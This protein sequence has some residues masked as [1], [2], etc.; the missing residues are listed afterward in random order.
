MD[1]G[2]RKNK[3]KEI[4]CF[5]RII[6]NLENELL[7]VD[8][9]N[10]NTLDN[11]KNNLRI[12]SKQQNAFNQKKKSKINKYKGIKKESKTTYSARIKYNY[13]EY[14]L[15]S[16]SSQTEAAIAYNLAALEF[17]GEFAYLNDIDGEEK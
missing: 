7:F 8:H 14:Y 17:F 12:C 5:H 15:G 10:H 6:L 9:I 13:I 2:E 3:K 4:V 11:R 16:Y 1:T